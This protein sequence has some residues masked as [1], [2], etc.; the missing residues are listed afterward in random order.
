MKRFVTKR[1]LEKAELKAI[2]G[3]WVEKELYTRLKA[4]Y[5][6]ETKVIN[7]NK[8]KRGKK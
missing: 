2:T 1:D 3:G 8:K 6:F 7:A 4:T 5:A